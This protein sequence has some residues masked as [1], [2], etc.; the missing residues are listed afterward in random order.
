VSLMVIAVDLKL[1][2]YELEGPTR[3]G[4]AMKDQA[5]LDGQKNGRNDRFRGTRNEHAWI[6]LLNEGYSRSYSLGYRHGWTR[7]NEGPL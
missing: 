7:P 3:G 2:E 4:T 6:V 5:W 1:A